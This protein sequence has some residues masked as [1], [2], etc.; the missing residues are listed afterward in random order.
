MNRSKK[1]AAKIRKLLVICALMTVIIAASTYA[2]FV[3]M[4]TVNVSSFDVEV[5]S[6]DS[7]LLSLNGVDW[8]TTVDISS[9]TFS[10]SSYVGNT[11]KWAGRGLIPMSTVGGM[12]TGA[13]RMK[14]FEK[15]SMTTTPGGYRLMASRV[16]NFSNPTGEEPDGYVVF[17]LFIKNFSGT[18]YIEDLNILDEEAIYLK[19]DS[20]VTVAESGVADTGIENSVRVAFA[21]IGRVKGSETDEELIQGL[22]CIS[23][24]QNDTTGICRTAQIWEPND[25]DHEANAIS[26]YEASCLARTGANVTSEASYSGACE[27][28]TDGVAYPTYAVNDDVL[29]SDNVDI[30]D[31]EEYNGYTPNAKA[32]GVDT[33]TD[34]EKL[35]VGTARPTFMMLAPNSITKVRIYI[36][37]EGQDID[38]YD[39]ASIGKAISVK[40]G[41]TKDRFD[42][43]SSIPEEES[44]AYTPESC[45][46]FSSGTI[47]SYYEHEGNVG[48]NPACPMDVVIPGTIGGAPVTTID[49]NAF[50]YYFLNSVIIPDSV[51]TIGDYAFSGNNFETLIIPD[52]VTTVGT[53]AFAEN[54]LTSVEISGSLTN[55][56]YGMFNYNKLTSVTIPDSVESIEA[57]AFDNNLLTSVTIPSSVMHIEA[58][59]FTNNKLTSVCIRS[60]ASSAAFTYYDEGA[61]EIWGW[62]TGYSE[63][64]ITWNCIN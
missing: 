15:A 61:G 22:S 30:Y 52:S 58:D 41:F 35:L 48:T 54:Q 53:N 12:D 32:A 56:K 10:S 34:T 37:I 64:N 36:Y 7:L 38:N 39:F 51:T 27:T 24:E 44:I 26:W 18:Q 19:T 31:G 62:D 60:K 45:F 3:G 28:L 46:N 13:S 33:F 47:N 4:R 2:W 57:F 21:Q 42:M 23:D 14:I 8:D 16:D 40:F 50:S 11:N 17:D 25:T 49:S 5:A 6:T 1:S 63:A 29:S 55:I 20:E 59:S 43:E 9:S